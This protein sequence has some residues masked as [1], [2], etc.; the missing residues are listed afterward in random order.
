MRTML[1]I[2]IP[3][4]PYTAEHIR[5]AVELMLTEGFMPNIK[6][7]NHTCPKREE[8]S[9]IDA[10]REAERRYGSPPPGESRHPLS[11]GH[12]DSMG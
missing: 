10:H 6:V 8:M 4:T 2:E 11:H 9:L 5:R 1:R 3:G 7:Y 12:R